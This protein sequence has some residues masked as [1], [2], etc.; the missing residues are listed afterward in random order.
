VLSH[1]PIAFRTSKAG[2]AAAALQIP[3]L[4]WH[5]AFA[6]RSDLYDW[7]NWLISRRDFF[8][9]WGY[10]ARLIFE[11]HGIP[12]TF[13]TSLP[14]DFTH[15]DYPL[16]VPLQFAVPSI[17]ARSWQPQA[18]GLLDTAL[19]GAAITVAYYCL[20]EVISWPDAHS[21]RGQALRMDRW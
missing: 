18:I 9:I 7:T 6:T 10:K 4:V 2:L 21:C 5:A 8:F 1:P 3:I 15:P 16:L 11:A 13:L 20:R 17:L 14:N 19:A 12:W